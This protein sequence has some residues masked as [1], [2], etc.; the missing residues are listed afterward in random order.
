MHGRTVDEVWVSGPGSDARGLNL[1]RDV[2]P[3][4]GQYEARDDWE[5]CSLRRHVEFGG[6]QERTSPR[7]AVPRLTP[8][9]N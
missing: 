2:L 5:S 7:A 6:C 3:G 9:D 1:A 4:P 8:N